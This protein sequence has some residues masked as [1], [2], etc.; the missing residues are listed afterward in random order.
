MLFNSPRGDVETGLW[1][2]DG[3]P[4][5][6]VVV[7][8]MRRAPVVGHLTGEVRRSDGQASNALM[9]KLPEG[10]EAVLTIVATPRSL[11]R[12]ISTACTARRWAIACWPARCAKTATPPAVTWARTTSSTRAPWLSS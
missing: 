11:W 7:E 12:T 4:Q 6:C 8:E 9:D 1:W 10:T 2:F 5:C 3:L